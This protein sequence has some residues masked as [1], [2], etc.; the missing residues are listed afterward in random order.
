MI[1]P[2][3]QTMQDTTTNLEESAHTLQC[4]EIW[5]GNHAIH[6]A[7][8]VTGLDA[9]ISSD[10]HKNDK[11]GG[12]IYYI[13]ACKCQEISRFAIVDVSGHG[14]AVSKFTQRL[15]SLMRKNI[16]TPDQTRF[17]RAL[18]EEFSNLE[19]TG[20]FATALLASYAPQTDHLVV[21]NAGHPRPLWYHSG[22]Q[23][24]ELLDSDL[25]QKASSVSNLPLGIIDSTSY[26]QFAVKLDKGDLILIYTDSLIEATNRKEQLLGEQGLLDR[27]RQLDPQR[28]NDLG[29]DLLA[30]VAAYR[31]DTP[32]DDDQTLLVLHHNA[33]DPPKLSLGQKMRMMTKMLGLID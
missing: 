32:P 18:N 27:I 33:A 23:T 31:D 14:E 30:L 20:Q 8:S 24:W 7:I 2:C 9:W 6:N 16:N 4:L 17:A 13:S 1:G 21:C 28:P 11:H 10:P 19:P 12:D 3:S 29:R 26:C 25:P 22:A 15:F 5:G